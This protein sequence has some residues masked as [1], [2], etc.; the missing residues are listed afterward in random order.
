MAAR[1][2]VLYGIAT[3]VGEGTV[4]GGTITPGDLLARSS[5]T[6]MIRHG[7]A[8]RN[9]AFL[10]ADNVPDR[11][12]GIDDDYSANDNVRV[13]VPTRGAIMNA[14]LAA[15]AA[16]VAIGDALESN[17][18]GKLRKHTPQAVNEG[19]AASYTIYAEAIVGYA[20]EAIDNSANGSP[21]RIRV[22]IR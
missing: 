14:N 15:N 6:Q 2:V 4:A 16:A 3:Q 12:K 1:K 11:N 7:N 10:F 22:E 19:G 8:G 17:G 13:V 5:A 21:V 9:H 18:N 20:L